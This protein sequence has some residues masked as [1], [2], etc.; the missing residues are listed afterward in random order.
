M[1]LESRPYVGTWRLNG[2]QLIQHTPDALVYVNGETSLPGC[3]KCSG[4]IDI[5]RFLTEVSVDAG[6]EPGSASASFSLAIPRHHNE[7]FA[8][9]AKFLLR[10]G[11]EIHVYMRGYFPV[12]GLYN[13]LA[14]GKVQ[15][16]ITSL[17]D[18]TPAM[19]EAE[20][21]PDPASPGTY[22]VDDILGGADVDA[23]TRANAATTAA[24]MNTL[25]SYLQQRYPGAKLSVNSAYTPARPQGGHADKSQHYQGSAV[26]IQAT[27]DAGP[28]SSPDI[29]RSV[30]KLRET[31]HLPRG[32]TGAYV[33]DGSTPDNP[34]WAGYVHMDHRGR[35]AWWVHDQATQT[36]VPDPVAYKGVLQT[37]LGGL[38]EP[39][40]TVQGYDA[41][42]PPPAVAPPA[43]TAGIQ[44]PVTLATTAQVGPSLLEEQG[45]AGLGIEDTLAY[46]YYH[47]FHGVIT[48]VSHSASGGV[49]SISVSCSSM[50]HFWQ[51]QNM[52]TNASLFGARPTNSKLKMSLVGHN[53]TGMHPYQIMYTL[54]HDMV[55]AA[56]GVGWALSNKTN[57]TAVSE[58][59][60][61]SLYSLNI[62]YWQKRFSGK[63]IRLRMH[64]ATGDLF[65]TMAAAWLGRTSS[66]NIMSLMRKRYSTAKPSAVKG[67]L[68]RV[69]LYNRNK[70][71]AL[72]AL[73]AL[74]FADQSHG[75]NVANK[76][77][78]GI[79]IVEMQ[80]FVSN[81][82]NWGQVNLFESS[83]ESKLD[84][85]QKVMEIT[86]FEFYQDVDGDFVF[87]PPM[88]NLDTSGS[89]VYR[90]E[91]IDII[92][93]GYSE[94]EPQVTYMTCKGS[95]FKNT[96]GTGLENEWGVR[97]QYIDYRLV[98]QFGWRPGSY[99]TAYF[100][101]SKSM[102]FSAVN[103][104]DVLN[105]G[106]NSA[107]VTIPV[108]PEIR[109]GF[110]VYVV[111]MDAFYYCNSFAHSH[112]VG[113]QCTTSLQLVGKRAKFYPPGRPGS[114]GAG[115]LADVDL[116]NT[117][118]PQRPIQV[119]SP[120]GTP[121][122]SGFPNVVMAL[123]PTAINPLF[124][125]VGN[126]M[127]DISDVR[128]IKYLL[129]FGEED[130]R[131]FDSVK[132]LENGGK[133]YTMTTGQKTGAGEDS[134]PITV[135]FYF[136]ED[137][138][139]GTASVPQSGDPNAEQPFNI[140]AEAINYERL[141]AEA[142]VAQEKDQEAVDRIKYDI[143]TMQSE[144]ANLQQSADS[145][146]DQVQA[147]LE[148]LS[149]DVAVLEDELRAKVAQFNLA[150]NIIQESWK[151]PSNPKA[152]G[153]A[154]LLEMLDQVG[155]AYRTSDDF[156]GRGDLGSA[157]A[158]LDMLSDK[159]AIFSNGSQP[160]SYRY[161]SASHPDKEHQGPSVIEYVSDV[162]GKT[163]ESAPAK[164]DGAIPTIKMFSPHPTAPFEGAIVPEAE[165][166][167]GQPEVGIRGLDG[168]GKEGGVSLATSDIMELMFSVQVVTVVKSVTTNFRT[169]NIGSLG[170]AA[171]AKISA[172]L[173]PVSAAALTATIADIFEPQWDSLKAKVTQGITAMKAKATEGGWNVGTVLAPA[174]PATV[175]LYKQSVSTGTSGGDDLFGDAT[176]ADLIFA[177]NPD[178]TIDLGPKG[179]QATQF[180]LLSH[181]GAKLGSDFYRKLET[182]RRTA[183]TALKAAGAKGPESDEVIGVFNTAL[184][185]VIGTSVAP[186]NTRKGRETQ[187]KTTTTSSPVFPVSDARGYEVIGS[188][189][190][191]REVSIE[192]EGV[193]DQ[194]HKT[195]LFSLLDK[196]LV[197]QILRS[198][199]QGQSIA[200]PSP[201]PV[202]VGDKTVTRPVGNG[203]MSVQSGAA[204][205]RYLN[206][207]VVRQLRSK[208]LT[209][210]QILDYGF[211]LDGG[212]S[213]QLQF[214]LAN[215]F[216]EQNLDGI[217]KIPVINAAY[218]LADM[219]LQQGGHICDCKAAE[220]DVHI[221]AFGQEQFL[222]FSQAGSPAHE[223]LGDDPAD[224]GTRW[225]AMTAA[226]ASV[227]W[228]QQQEAL[229][230][231]VLDRGGSHIVKQVVETLGI[232]TGPSG[233]DFTETLGIEGLEPGIRTSVFEKTNA[234][235]QRNFTD[236]DGPLQEAIR[237]AE[238]NGLN[239]TTPPGGD[240]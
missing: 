69:G 47:V 87:K 184:G 230:G 187:R 151:D 124:F 236:E 225:V 6:T 80:A 23:E 132:T 16:E 224:A 176:L 113:G 50:L 19:I 20:Q 163:Q 90:I 107:N 5:Q 127:A 63:A 183:A 41:S 149:A 68:E 78:F 44:E 15:N 43:T 121:K 222:S 62:R 103:R 93:I 136:Q 54:H 168:S 226:Q 115:F 98:A 67:V 181:A 154:F 10:P 235:A 58:V 7:S 61:E 119:L 33:Y 150:K 38:P 77:D 216:T 122:L 65:S 22:G 198:F 213:N 227:S 81:I 72:D 141:V 174:F 133:V 64:G 204:T 164:I 4:R 221:L 8:R 190:Y 177:D 137:D 84:V 220:A 53:F 142:T 139:K 114:G 233:N 52:S 211:L 91:D 125:V 110:P 28:I 35:S 2:R 186:S 17:G 120:D 165:L 203:E 101:D 237:E 197:E 128:V 170:P 13:N 210:K 86:G 199:V 188:Y 111:Y 152:R 105:I 162:K 82:G 209:D 185:A 206:D 232:D 59:G 118:L 145:N 202:Q 123:D 175:V 146:T 214:S 130:G 32:G 131:I 180:D 217:Q 192:P 39:N 92:N 218:S 158:L 153:V 37:G 189:R 14:E 71:A 135:R 48:E 31:G 179:A 144:K 73:E 112:A 70:R 160:G 239:L 24:M 26:D 34:L 117:I 234:E 104:M 29:W 85:A 201:S 196:T 30:E 223:G 231:Q 94:K 100:N 25:E 240:Q 159:K 173:A 129:K 161:Y 215:I 194:L 88:W 55:G 74:E 95:Q 108:R 76:P 207:E 212:E 140:I 147:K 49:G 193:F 167:D 79:N 178:G 134:Q 66:S 40:S 1:G 27:S 45:L 205:S 75:G 143:I 12:A 138:F 116:G 182:I 57:Q 83:Y 208:N 56:G 60:G 200:T 102:F 51:Y 171:R 219:D 18:V 172:Q 42:E 9:D 21:L 156:Q 11:L 191:G 155:A 89:R 106:I 109:P 157:T 96:A 97:G 238:Q 99:E 36:M 169:T 229:R 166:V 3:S 195:D 126:D 46:P 148:T 228:Q